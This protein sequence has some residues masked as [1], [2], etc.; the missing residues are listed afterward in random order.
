MLIRLVKTGRG[1]FSMLQE[2]SALKKK[3][4]YLQKLKEEER[5]KFQPAKKISEVHYGDILLT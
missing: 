4:Q 5:H 3:Q 2:E 1:Y